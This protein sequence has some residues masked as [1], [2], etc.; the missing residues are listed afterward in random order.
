MNRVGV[1]LGD[2]ILTVI[3]QCLDI[4]GHLSLDPLRF[5]TTEESCDCLPHQ[6]RSAH[7]SLPGDSIETFEQG[8]RKGNVNIR[9]SFHT[10]I[11]VIIQIRIQKRLQRR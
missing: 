6:L 1:G 8:V 2:K 9:S 7:A 10:N 5:H 4:I 11:L 3:G